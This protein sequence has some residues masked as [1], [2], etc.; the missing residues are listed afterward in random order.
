MENSTVEIE[1]KDASKLST[2]LLIGSDGPNS[3]IRQNAK[4][5]ITK[6][7][8]D[9]VALVATVKLAEVILFTKFNII[10]NKKH[11]LSYI[12]IILNMIMFEKKNVN[13]TAWQR[14]LSTG[15]IALLPVS[16]TFNKFRK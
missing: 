13:E 11:F 1:L 14:F 5:N 10:A 3:Y 16:Y 12:K 2:S 4:F 7:D 9:Q 15:P 6:W 8:Y